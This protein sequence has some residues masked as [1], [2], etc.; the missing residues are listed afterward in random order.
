MAAQRHPFPSDGGAGAARVGAGG[1]SGH[2]T[3]PRAMPKASPPYASE[4]VRALGGEAAEDMSSRQRTNLFR[5]RRSGTF[6][7]QALGPCF[8]RDD[9]GASG[10]GSLLS[11]GRRWGV[12]R[13]GTTGGLGICKEPKK[14]GGLAAA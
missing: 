10:A 13:A 6:G 1:S 7:R 11:Q 12:G 5:R 3:A 8:R 9:D 2:V 14:E 4:N